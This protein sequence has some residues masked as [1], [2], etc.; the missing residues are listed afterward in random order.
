MIYNNYYKYYCEY[1]FNSIAETKLKNISESSNNQFRKYFLFSLSIFVVLPL[2]QSIIPLIHLYNINNLQLNTNSLMLFLQHRILIFYIIAFFSFV[3]YYRALGVAS[4]KR[5]EDSQKRS[6]LFNKNV[7]GLLRYFVSNICL[8]IV[9]IWSNEFVFKNG[10]ESWHPVP[11][12]RFICFLV[13]S[14]MYGI[15]IFLVML[16]FVGSRNFIRGDLKKIIEEEKIK[17]YSSIYWLYF[18]KHI[19][20]STPPFWIGII[21]LNLLSAIG[22]IVIG[23]PS[24]LFEQHFIFS[25]A[26]YSFYFTSVVF[27][28]GPIL[29]GI[30]RINSV[31][32]DYALHIIRNSVLPNLNNH[33]VLLGIGSLGSQVIRNCFEHIHPEGYKTKSLSEEKDERIDISIEDLS[34]YNLV[35]DKNLKLQLISQRIVVFDSDPSKFN[36]LFAG[37][38][39]LAIG[40]YTP[41]LEQKIPISLIG[42]NQNDIN[43][44]VLNTLA[45]DRASLIINATPNSKHSLFMASKYRKKQILSVNDSYTF[46][47]LTSTTYDKGVYLIDT[48]G[49]EGIMLS[50]LVFQWVNTNIRHNIQAKYRWDNK[51]L[52]RV[53]YKRNNNQLTETKFNSS[54]LK[55]G[56]GKVLIVGS[57]SY[58]YHFIKSLILTMALSMR[59]DKE[60]IKQAIQNKLY[61]LTNDEFIEQELLNENEKLIWKFY[62]IRNSET[63]TDEFY[64]ISTFW[65]SIANFEKYVELLSSID[66]PPEMIILVNPHAYT[67]ID[68]FVSVSTAI[69][70]INRT[71]HEKNNSSYNPHIIVYS[72]QNDEYYLIRHFKKY[73]TLNRGRQEKI[74]YPTQ[75]KKESCIVKDSLS[76]LR[77]SAILRDLYTID[78]YPKGGK[79]DQH[80]VAEITF[81]AREQNGSLANLAASLVNRELSYSKHKE[82]KVPRFLNYYS[83]TDTYY[84]NTFLFKGLAKL[85]KRI[86]ISSIKEIVNYCFI[87][88]EKDSQKVIYNIVKSYLGIENPKKESVNSMVETFKKRDSGMFSNY[89]GSS[90]LR[91]PDKYYDITFR[92][93]R[94][95]LSENPPSPLINNADE[96]LAEINEV[97]FTK[98]LKNSFNFGDFTIW[99]DGDE[100]SGSLA[101]VLSEVILCTTCKKENPPGLDTKGQ[102]I[103]VL[104]TAN[105]PSPFHED[106]NLYYT[107]DSF[108]IRLKP[109][110]NTNDDSLTRG[111]IRAIKVKLTGEIL[112]ETLDWS[113][114]LLILKQHLVDITHHTYYLYMIEKMFVEGLD[115]EGHAVNSYNGL[116]EVSFYYNFE[117]ESDFNKIELGHSPH[118][119]I[120]RGWQKVGEIDKWKEL[121]SVKFSDSFSTFHKVEKAQVQRYEF[122]LIREDIVEQSKIEVEKELQF[123][124]AQNKLYYIDDI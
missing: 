69:E 41:W 22:F 116:T 24:D 77:F 23:G 63:K 3:F 71:L 111:L 29:T 122:V 10:P 7:I 101:E 6:K 115:V 86:D 25:V 9:A 20:L 117:N 2:L 108:Y 121:P 28:V 62:P 66:Q 78:N 64:K 100:E 50:Q 55:F 51:N 120:V 114:Y 112:L 14:L 75:L 107:Q 73:L 26:F 85:E 47:T 58:I 94:F 68:M 30:R 106:T 61:L 103:L 79:K 44:Q 5:V 95:L 56:N 118:F 96:K 119:E 110:T 72:T 45:I 35:I 104:H 27:I 34:D 53:I 99:S 123:G 91:H 39:D 36:E 1:R 17:K 11:M 87:N 13:T 21:I 74:G 16:F 12:F 37:Y 18:I 76:A 102:E 97:D 15:S 65:G 88:C 89:P 70:V 124:K 8:I 67:A 90:I 113:K 82:E 52:K 31:Y 81:S 84:K 4:R 46:D 49:I 98:Y 109:K 92:R 42:V 57:G 83:T 48:Q 59:F 40:T 43:E 93:P 80:H 38:A 32:N 54:I 33:I 19:F 105:R 60:A